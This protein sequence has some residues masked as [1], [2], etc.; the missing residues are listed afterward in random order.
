[1]SSG[2]QHELLFGVIEAEG[3]C[4]VSITCKKCDLLATGTG[5]VSDWGGGYTVIDS[6][7]RRA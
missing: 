7:E 5:I 4:I 6:H 3:E 2:C 1:M